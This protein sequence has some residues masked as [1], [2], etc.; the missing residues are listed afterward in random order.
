MRNA[1]DE[2][3]KHYRAII[4]GAKEI[5]I[6]ERRRSKIIDQ[7]NS[8]IDQIRDQFVQ[9]M[10][11]F[12]AA[13][14]FNSTVSFLTLFVVLALGTRFQ[15]EKTA[16]SGFILVMLYVRGPIEQMVL[17][18]PLLGEARCHSA[19]CLSCLPPSQEENCQRRIGP[20]YT[21]REHRF[22]CANARYEFPPPL[23]GRVLRTW[24]NQ[25][26]DQSR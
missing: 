5:R 21:L 7:L 3:Q 26:D 11:V 1:H 22:I 14:A 6:N 24:T 12:F 18:L 8:T 15:V 9:A 4:E 17:A 20:R 13:R 19:R 25:P 16:V 10:R 23:D 2:L